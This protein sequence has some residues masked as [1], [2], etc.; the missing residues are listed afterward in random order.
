MSIDFFYVL[1]ELLIFFL[2]SIVFY[3]II[4]ENLLPILYR[5]ISN[6]KKKQKDFKEE[7]ELLIASHDRLD[8]QIKKQKDIFFSLEKKVCIWRT[9]INEKEKQQQ[10][11]NQLLF[12]SIEDKR[13]LQ[14]K[15][16]NLLKMQKIV[17]PQAIIKATDEISSLYGGDKS[18]SLLRELIE[19]IE[20]KNASKS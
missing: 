9:D 17:I 2:F 16:L 5:Q 10:I 6:I 20:P 19:K 11:E 4:K 7:T 18:L 3:K 15:N 14:D 1:F 13:K 12:K 8:N